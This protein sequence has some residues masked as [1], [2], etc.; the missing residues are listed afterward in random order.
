M[1]NR[2]KCT[3]PAGMNPGVLV[4]WKV[5]RGFHFCLRRFCRARLERPPEGCRSPCSL[6]IGAKGYEGCSC[7]GAAEWGAERRAKW[8]SPS[9]FS[10]GAE[11]VCLQTTSLPV[12]GARAV[13]VVG[14]GAA[15]GI[16]QPGGRAA[17][18]KLSRPKSPAE[19]SRRGLLTRGHSELMSASTLAPSGCAGARKNT[20][21]QLSSVGRAGGC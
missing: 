3:N 9:A 5:A 17:R 13:T 16:G 14:V 4:E 6:L 7:A 19:L 11:N 1:G 2:S 20:T 12:E 15:T 10:E 21:F 18:A 8:R